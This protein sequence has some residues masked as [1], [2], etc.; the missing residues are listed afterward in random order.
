MAITGEMFEHRDGG[1]VDDGA[2]NPSSDSEPPA[3]SP[4]GGSQNPPGQTLRVIDRPSSR[5]LLESV[6]G[7]VTGFFFGL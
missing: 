3:G 7:G 5:G 2:P 6:V 4:G 1:F